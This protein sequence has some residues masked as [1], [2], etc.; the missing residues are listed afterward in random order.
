MLPLNPTE[1]SSLSTKWKRLGDFTLFH[2]SAEVIMMEAWHWLYPSTLQPPATLIPSASFGSFGHESSTVPRPK[3]RPTGHYRPVSQLLLEEADD[4]SQS[5]KSSRRDSVSLFMAISDRS[6]LD[7]VHKSLRDKEK[8]DK[9]RGPGVVPSCVAKEREW[10]VPPRSGLIQEVS[11]EPFEHVANIVPKRFHDDGDICCSEDVLVKEKVRQDLYSGDS[12][13][14]QS[15]DRIMVENE[16]YTNSLLRRL[17]SSAPTFSTSMDKQPSNVLDLG[18]GQGYW[19]LDASYHWPYAKFA[20][21]DL[22]DVM[23]PEVRER[24]NIRLVQG[25][26]VSNSLPFPDQSF[27]FVR[28]ADLGLAIPHEKWSFV[29]SEA[30]RVLTVGG[31]IE[32]IDD[33]LFFPYGPLPDVSPPTPPL[34]V[35]SKSLRHNA[36]RCRVKSNSGTPIFDG[37]EANSTYIKPVKNGNGFDSLLQTAKVSQRRSEDYRKQWLSACQISH[38][39][40]DTFVG[41]LLKNFVHPSPHAFISDLLGFT[42]GSQ[43]VCNTQT[44]DIQL[45]PLSSAPPHRID[46][47]TS[48]RFGDCSDQGSSGST[49]GKDCR[50]SPTSRE[51]SPTQSSPSSLYSAK[52]ADRLGISYSDLVAV[53]T[54]MKQPVPDN[55]NSYADSVVDEICQSPGIIVS[56]STFIPLTSVETEFHACKWMHTLL[57]W[58]TAL[59]D[60]IHS[61]TDDDG[62]IIVADS[63]WNDALWT[64]ES[65]RRQ[66]FHW[67]M[68]AEYDPDSFASPSIISMHNRDLQ[69]FLE[70]YEKPVQIRT[71]RVYHATKTGMTS[72]ASLPSSSFSSH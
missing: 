24:P 13:Y 27:D 60:H 50:H 49:E 35:G 32:V 4:K 39:V 43:N 54:S 37:H 6:L 47:P 66:R 1:C 15:Y 58:R 57:G 31:Q 21:F 45:A 65:F 71:I 44:F 55:R 5:A 30:R 7:V 48:L 46:T 70:N 53:T 22:V 62:K 38:D 59:A 52:A 51:H 40:E 69:S 19:L 28:L 23:L 61:C 33:Q 72:F 56:P 8:K 9:E 14:M 42:F 34:L 20:G 17:A 67:P 64:Y 16:M 36:S 10:S 26:F 29:I 2:Y 68:N 63:E 25:N 11:I 12:V 18:C 41:M 3:G